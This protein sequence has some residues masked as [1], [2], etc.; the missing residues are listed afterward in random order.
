MK[1]E[2]SV[3]SSTRKGCI[4]G[5]P[6]PAALRE[7]GFT[8]VRL[9]G[10]MSPDSQ[11]NQDLGMMQQRVVATARVRKEWAKVAHKTKAR[12]RQ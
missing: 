9:H 11:R 7:A 1:G 10:E 12:L 3:I 8:D 2:S 4:P 6:S 5:K